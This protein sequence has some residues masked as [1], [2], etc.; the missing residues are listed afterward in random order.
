MLMGFANLMTVPLRVEYLANARYGLVLSVSMVAVLTG[1]IPNALRL[2]LA[3]VWGW[4]FDRLNFFALR[5]VLNAGF[6]ISILTFF[7]SESLPG[8]V[9]GAVIFGV[10]NAGGDVAWMLWVT[11][12]APPGK[13]ADYM[14]VHTFFTGL[15]GAVAPLVAFH[16]VSRLSIGTVGGVSALLIALATAILAREL[17]RDRV[18]D[19]G[20]RLIEAATSDR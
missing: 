11:K 6:A 10:C 5:V 16:L 2:L 20:T 15:R 7:T 18:V 17:R 8:L 19:P 12:V 13:V 14:A 3:P 1:V 9:T 4:A